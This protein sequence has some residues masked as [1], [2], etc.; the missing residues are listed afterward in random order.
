[1]SLPNSQYLLFE[2]V[3]FDV[4]IFLLA[5]GL[6][7]HDTLL[8]IFS[9][10]YGLQLTFNHILLGTLLDYRLLEV[11]D[12]ILYIC[13]PQALI[14]LVSLDKTVSSNAQLSYAG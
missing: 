10:R 11:W 5:N 4:G 7:F 3:F 14:Q 6:K 12:T 13:L 2:E 9:G 1:M 8:R